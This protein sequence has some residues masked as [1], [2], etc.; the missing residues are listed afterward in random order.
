MSPYA[1]PRN[2][3][4]QARDQTRRAYFD[5][6]YASQEDPYG[7]R[8]RWYEQRKLMV[9]LASLPNLHYE[10]AF[11][12][13]CGTGR[14]T[15]ELARRCRRVLA[16]DLSLVAVSR[17]RQNL[18]LCDNV[19]L[20]QQRLPSDWPSE[21]DGFDLIVLSEVLSYLDPGEVERTSELCALSLRPGGC[22]VACDWVAEFDGRRSGCLAAHE[23]L[24][25]AGMPRVLRHEEDD[26]VLDVWCRGEPSIA[27]GEGLR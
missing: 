25:G 24:H 5:R 9:L 12:P 7:V 20:C 4:H 8:S 13:A 14:L 19:E 27:K 1:A 17:A 21:P 3:P 16:S 11:E 2:E 23:I 10:H 22:L 26:F 6:L 18:S 15:M